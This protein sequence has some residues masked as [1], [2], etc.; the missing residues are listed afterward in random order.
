MSYKL[1]KKLRCVFDT[2]LDKKSYYIA[3]VTGK[4]ALVAVS[5]SD[6][7]SHLYVSEDLDREGDKIRFTLSLESVLCYFPNTTW[8]DSWLQ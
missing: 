4:R 1:G 3:D 6:N 2:E 7:L 8:Y 5:H